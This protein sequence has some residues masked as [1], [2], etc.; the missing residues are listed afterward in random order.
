M[1]P[2]PAG[3]AAATGS[4]SPEPPRW[5]SGS[6]SGCPNR[7]WSVDS[8]AKRGLSCRGGGSLPW[9][10]HEMESCGDIVGKGPRAKVVR[11]FGGKVAGQKG[12]P[13]RSTEARRPFDGRRPLRRDAVA[14]QRADRVNPGLTSSI[15][16]RRPHH[17]GGAKPGEAVAGAA[18][19]PPRSP[20]SSNGLI[21]GAP[22]YH[23]QDV[24]LAPP[25]PA[26]LTIRPRR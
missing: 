21:A 11:R 3:P 1:W 26:T 8:W 24:R 14:N 19:A 10:L 18:S 4:P 22:N 7:R 5:R 15:R 23:P 13:Q 25:S 2:N 6:G 16:A 9:P 20:R 17:V 12:A